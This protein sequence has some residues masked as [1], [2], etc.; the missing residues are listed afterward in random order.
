MNSSLSSNKES[1]CD[2]VFSKKYIWATVIGGMVAAMIQQ[3]ATNVF[4][5]FSS[6]I[7]V[8]MNE[9]IPEER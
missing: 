6:R 7:I 4:N 8:I 5:M 9:K 2:K 1:Y 3:S